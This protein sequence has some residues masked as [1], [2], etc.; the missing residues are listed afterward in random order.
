MLNI[1]QIKSI[2]YHIR[3]IEWGSWEGII[4]SSPYMF[5]SDVDHRM[6]LQFDLYFNNPK[7]CS[8]ERMIGWA[9]PDL[10]FLLQGGPVNIFI[11]CTFKVVPSAFVQLMISMMFKAS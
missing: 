3:H 7:T 6:F 9:H 10:I 4:K 1:D 8:A 11:D 2:V 5:V